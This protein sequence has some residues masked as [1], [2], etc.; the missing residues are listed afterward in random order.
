MFP[1]HLVER[2]PEGIWLAVQ[3][4]GS[5]RMPRTRNTYWH[6]PPGVY[7]DDLGQYCFR[8]KSG[9]IFCSDTE[10]LEDCGIVECEDAMAKIGFCRA[11]GEPVQENCDAAT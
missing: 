4:C 1:F 7:I 11:W 5:K 8:M 3:F 9:C 6:E 2:T 10:D